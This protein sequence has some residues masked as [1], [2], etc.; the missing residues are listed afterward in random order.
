MIVSNLYHLAPYPVIGWTEGGPPN[1]FC[2]DMAAQ[3]D[4]Y[5]AMRARTVENIDHFA[6]FNL[7]TI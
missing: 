3:A 7:A 5:L 4:L 2:V 1:Q 6:D